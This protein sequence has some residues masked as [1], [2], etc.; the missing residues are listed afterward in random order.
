M[1]N[2]SKIRVEVLSPSRAPM[3]AVNAEIR[4]NEVV[5]QKGRPGRGNPTITAE[6]TADCIIPYYAGAWPFK[7]LKQKLL[8]IQNTKKCCEISDK[9]LARGI[10][11]VE[12]FFESASMKNAGATREKHETSPILFFL[13][14]GNIVLTVVSLLMLSGRLII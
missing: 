9:K 12:K 2:P 6:F 13:V 8:W 7:R 5:I 1:R 14:G 3:Y 4:G 11:D 10:F